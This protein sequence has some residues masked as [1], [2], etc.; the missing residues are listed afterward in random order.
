MLK[1]YNLLP[2]AVLL[3]IP[4]SAQIIVD[5][6]DAGDLDDFSVE[7][8]G[9][10]QAAG[11]GINGSGGLNHGDSTMSAGYGL[12]YTAAS[13]SAD[14]V[15]F[16]RDHSVYFYFDADGQSSTTTGTDRSAG[17]GLTDSEANADFGNSAH[18]NLVGILIKAPGNSTLR[19]ETY[20]RGDTGTT[21]DA[22]NFS[23]T[24]NTWYRV[25]MN[26]TISSATQWDVTATV[27]DYGSDGLTAGSQVADS[28]GTIT[29]TDAALGTMWFAMTQ[30]EN[31]RTGIVAYDNLAVPEP[32]TFALLAGLSGLG[33]VL[34]RRRR[35]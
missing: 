35:R 5:F 22:Q 4:L 16:S 32:G 33:F 10:Q 15:G 19:L 9:T 18:Q 8:G 27:T 20:G 34:Y 26:F 31:D 28:N 21:E 3:T 14:S 7:N 23:V 11:V 24:D 17:F 1:R 6:E 2:L 25:D 12:R 13:F 30:A 29:F